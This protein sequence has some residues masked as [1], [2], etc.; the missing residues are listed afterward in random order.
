MSELDYKVAIGY[1]SDS[2]TLSKVNSYLAHLRKRL[3]KEQ[4]EQM[5]SWYSETIKKEEK[6]VRALKESISHAEEYFKGRK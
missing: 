6:Y 3:A 4:D 1:A 2:V 5:I